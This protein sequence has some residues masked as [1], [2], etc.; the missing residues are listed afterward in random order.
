[1]QIIPTVAKVQT[2]DFLSAPVKG[3]Q[4][5]SQFAQLGNDGKNNAKHAD[6]LDA[7]H[8]ALEDVE[9]GT[10]VSV[11]AALADEAQSGRSAPLVQGPYSRNTTDGVLY[12]LDEV[13]FTKKELLEL[14]AELLKAGAP[15]GALKKFDALA[16]QP[17][18]A[19]LAQV[20]AG[21]RD[22]ATPETLDPQDIHNIQS[23]LGKIDPTGNLSDQSLAL[24]L[25]GKGDK[26]LALVREVFTALEKAGGIEIS[27]EESL[28]FGRGLGL[29]NNALQAIA[30][31]FG[32]QDAARVTSALFS[33]LM[34]PA[35]MQFD[36]QATQ[37][38]QINE[39]LNKTLQ[40][41]VSK[42]RARMEKEEAASALSDRKADRGKTRIDKAVRK[43][44]YKTLDDTLK[45]GQRDDTAAEQGETITSA[46]VSKKTNSGH[47]AAVG[48]QTEPDKDFYTLRAGT[49]KASAD[50][51]GDDATAKKPAAHAAPVKPVANDA[52]KE[53]GPDAKE[54]PNTARDHT[55]NV[56]S[57]PNQRETDF[58]ADRQSPRHAAPRPEPSVKPVDFSHGADVLRPQAAQSPIKASKPF[59]QES[60]IT[61]RLEQAVLTAIADTQ[62]DPRELGAVSIVLTQ[63]KGEVI[64]SIRPEKTETAELLIKKMDAIQAGLEQAGVKIDKL[65]VR[66]DNQT[67]GQNH[68]SGD[69]PKQ[70][71]PKTAS[72]PVQSK[73]NTPTT[74]STQPGSGQAAHK[75]EVRLDNQTDGQN[76]NSGDN[77]KQDQPKTTTTSAAPVQGKSNGLTDTPTTTRPASEH[78]VHQP[79]G[80]DMPAP[81]ASEPDPENKATLP[82]QAANQVEG[83]LLTTL[84]DGATRMSLRLNPEEL[85]AVTLILTLR[86]GEVSARILSD[87]NETAEM[88]N[89]QLE[90]IRANLEQQGV[91]VDKLEVQLNG[92]QRQNDPRQNL[93]QHNAWQENSSR[94]EELARLK[95]LSTMR[96]SRENQADAALEQ[97]VQ[98]PG[99][100][101]KYADQK[102]HLVA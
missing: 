99:H 86:N 49:I 79:V 29:D 6:F 54:I 72:S 40:P 101:A 61:Q 92:D 83:A 46:A 71:Q 94:R 27:R 33:D 13:C 76:H 22:F 14:R 102:L 88:L 95:N 34:I 87:K 17:D 31:A 45:A 82:R 4:N 43:K 84:R 51:N 53:A 63:A 77:P 80:H 5:A 78:A 32:G 41:I 18:G 9:E 81:A 42:A 100:T 26:A 60:P 85:G 16:G 38:Q 2:T 98:S 90:N 89:S 19:T 24:M 69:R 93:D 56:S 37:Q 64:A 52:R 75:L 62:V 47:S 20:M 28:S 48:S 50:K 65:E 3:K 39:A 30:G 23:L 36:R 96:H 74:A 55:V 1:M 97:P 44:S 58:T 21:L 73:P 91:K 66:L 59:G 57:A 67:D 15:E 8:E 68:N 7:I 11:A 10:H 25:E 12:T 70:D 35:R